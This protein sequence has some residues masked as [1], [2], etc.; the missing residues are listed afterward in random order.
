MKLNPMTI[1]IE[2]AK[3]QHSGARLAQLAGI[4]RQTLSAVL[5][6]KDCAEQTAGK[7]ARALDMDVEELMEV[8]DNG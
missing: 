5:H 2:M 8:N 7:L 6:G 1:R 3:R 4:S